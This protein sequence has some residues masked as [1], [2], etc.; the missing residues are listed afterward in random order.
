MKGLLVCAAVLLWTV[1]ISAEPRCATPKG[2]RYHAPQANEYP[3]P[4]Y[5]LT[6]GFANVMFGWLEIP[7]GF[8]YENSRI[9]LVGVVSGPVKGAFLTVWREVAGVI[10]L[11]SMGLSQQG[12]YFILPDYVWDAPWI[13][14]AQYMVDDPDQT[15][16][17]NKPRRV[18]SPRKPGAALCRPPAEREP[19]KLQQ[20]PEPCKLQPP[21]PR[22]IKQKM[23]VTKVGD[24]SQPD[25]TLVQDQPPANPFHIAN[26]ADEYADIV[27]TIDEQVLVIEGRASMVR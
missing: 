7:R 8:T 1:S 13:H 9:P 24:T 12:A 18:D 14:R 25:S 26:D 17:Y 4:A 23:R 27:R 19:C 16:R 22:A 3:N 21:P 20:S 6:R 15:M 5:G 10:D 11:V 2:Q